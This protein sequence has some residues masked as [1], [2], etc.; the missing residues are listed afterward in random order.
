MPQVLGLSDVSRLQVLGS[1]S[2][3]VMQYAPY[4]PTRW[5]IGSICPLTEV[6]F[7]KSLHS[8]AFPLC[9]KQIV[10]AK[11]ILHSSSTFHPLVLASVD[12]L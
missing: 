12:I 8:K 9:N 2:T 4:H 6:V 1:N 7:H 11:S 5:H 10:E 3:E